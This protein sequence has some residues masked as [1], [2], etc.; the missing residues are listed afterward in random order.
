MLIAYLKIDTVLAEETLNG[1]NT[2]S[3]P[4]LQEYI[5]EGNQHFEDLERCF[6]DL[7]NIEVRP[8]VAALQN[9][10]IVCN[11]VTNLLFLLYI[12]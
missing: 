11:I 9:L 7:K 12:F 6:N 5:R 1:S 8:K 4:S 2:A 10:C 3:V